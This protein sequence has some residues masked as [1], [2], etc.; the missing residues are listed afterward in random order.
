MGREW[1]M[2]KRDLAALRS[3]FFKKLIVG[4]LAGSVFWQLS[5]EQKGTI[6]LFTLHNLLN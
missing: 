3:R 5:N 2:M 1:I 6:F 4:I